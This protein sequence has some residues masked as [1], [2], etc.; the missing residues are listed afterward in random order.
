MMARG[1]GICTIE[2]CGRPR[3]G[4]GL[5]VTRYFRWR[6]TGDPQ[7]V[8]RSGVPKPYGVPG[9][10]RHHEPHGYCPMHLRCWKRYGDPSISAPP[11]PIRL[12]VHCGEQHPMAKLT[13]E[14]VRSLRAQF[15]AGGATLAELGARYAVTASSVGAIVKGKYWKEP[16][17]AR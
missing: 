5:C 13:W 11:T 16:Q 2:G 4:H 7:S 9:C 1:R 14:Q 3:Q 10:A 17:P 8:R 12:P 6:R 15:A